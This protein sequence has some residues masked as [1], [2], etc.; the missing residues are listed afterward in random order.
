MAFNSALSFFLCLFFR[1]D[2]SKAKEA[3]SGMLES[4]TSLLSTTPIRIL[5]VLVIVQFFWLFFIGYLF[6]PYSHDALMYHVPAASYFFQAGKIYDSVVTNIRWIRLYPKNL[7]LL[8]LW[9]M[10]FLRSDILINCTQV[11][12]LLFGCAALF[13]LN[14]KLGVSRDIALFSAS[15]FLFTP[16][17][18]QQST[19][20]MS[21]VAFASLF[22]ITL[23]FL[24]EKSLKH[25]WLGGCS[26]GIMLGVKGTGILFACSIMSFIFAQSIFRRNRLSKKKIAAF[27]IPLVLLGGFW[28]L[29]NLVL[30]GNPI[31]PVPVTCGKYTLF[32]GQKNLSVHDISERD[33]PEA[34]ASFSRWMRVWRSWQ[35]FNFVKYA[36][37]YK[38]GGFGPLFFIFF[39]PNLI[40]ALYSTLTDK[41]TNFLILL[42]PFMLNFIL[43]RSSWYSRHNIQFIGLFSVSSGITI[44]RIHIKKLVTVSMSILLFL[45]IIMGNVREQ[46][47]FSN[48]IRF[49]RMP[50]AQRV[51]A[52]FYIS[53]D[54]NKLFRWVSGNVRN[55]DAVGYSFQTYLPPY[56]LWNYSNTVHCILFKTRMEWQR[57][58]R[59]RNIRY[60][61]VTKGDVEEKWLAEAPS[62]YENKTYIVKFL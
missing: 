33:I 23:N 13:G 19:L 38:G 4:M 2:T 61:I 9:Q 41:N 37:Y 42:I 47:S 29:K 6:P 49:L 3:L 48:V 60:Y 31:F 11:I 43:F 50:D 45:N 24:S 1:V 12:F 18:I 10:V 35:E 32:R 40:Y 17:V 54:K 57:K 53:G 59:S 62:A 25:A 55:F 39:L 58:V 14:R 51:S 36:Y 46:A 52:N 26:G 44:S 30:H 22:F 28:Y 15:I 34:L 21:D 8:F 5:F 16:L 20:A 27:L 56:P 7:E